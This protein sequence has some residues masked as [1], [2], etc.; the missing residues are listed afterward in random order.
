M[1]T[2][3]TE[4]ITPSEFGTLM[5]QL[6]EALH[7][8]IGQG[9]IRE[10]FETLDEDARGFTY[11]H[12]QA[13]KDEARRS[14][15]FFPKPHKLVEFCTIARAK[16]MRA[17]REAAMPALPSKPAE[18]RDACYEGDCALTVGDHRAAFRALT[19]QIGRT[20]GET[21]RL[22]PSYLEQQGVHPARPGVTLDEHV[23]E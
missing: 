17:L 20:S 21:A 14:C 11:L 22:R 8:K 23:H 12:V 19:E 4:R 5:F 18:D 9:T 3:A 2:D 7:T 6:G 16:D 1:T 15:E 13:A 10:Y